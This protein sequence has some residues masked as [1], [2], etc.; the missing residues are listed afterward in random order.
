M[1]GL[2][3][4]DDI[5]LAEPR[6]FSEYWTWYTIVDLFFFILM[7]EKKEDQGSMVCGKRIVAQEAYI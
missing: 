6:E 3:W 4:A 7:K 5:E 1:V 2:R